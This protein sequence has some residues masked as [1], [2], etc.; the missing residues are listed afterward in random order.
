MLPKLPA[1]NLYREELGLSVRKSIH[2]LAF[3]QRFIGNYI[4]LN[5]DEVQLQRIGLIVSWKLYILVALS[6][7]ISF[8]GK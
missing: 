8:P 4:G 7:I 2:L 6:F 1:F 5:F 3:F